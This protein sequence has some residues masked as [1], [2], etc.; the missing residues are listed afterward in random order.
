MFF[1]LQI[2]DGNSL[3]LNILL[4]ENK[5]ENN[6]LGFHCLKSLLLFLSQ[7]LPS[8]LDHKY[9]FGNNNNNNNSRRKHLSSFLLPTLTVSYHLG[10]L[11]IN[12]AAK[13]C[14]VKA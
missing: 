10:G 5:R 9:Y 4:V 13:E 8:I 3:V 11:R 14:L 12:I 6:R 1:S 7:I 2:I